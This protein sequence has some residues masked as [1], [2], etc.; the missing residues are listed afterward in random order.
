MAVNDVALSAA[1]SLDLA[2]RLVE[3]HIDDIAEVL[4][5]QHYDTLDDIITKL[6][7]TVNELNDK[8]SSTA[9]G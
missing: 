9:T 3:Q 1:C 6:S 2:K 5:G 8:G 7:C 4:G